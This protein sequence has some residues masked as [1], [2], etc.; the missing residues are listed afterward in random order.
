MLKKLFK[1][2]VIS[3]NGLKY[4]YNIDKTIKLELFLTI[5]VIFTI[6]FCF[7]NREIH[8]MI[9]LWFLIIIT[10]LLNTALE[11]TVGLISSET[12]EKIKVIKDISS[13]A[14]F[15]SVLIFLSSFFYFL[16]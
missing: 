3:L 8:L 2:I 1:S 13:A 14:V 12:N 5:P 6:F 10:E 4:A 16:F 15:L 11:K 7:E 9:V